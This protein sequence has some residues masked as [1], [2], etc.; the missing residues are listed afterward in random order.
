MTRRL[1]K[2]LALIIYIII[3]TSLPSAS[4]ELQSKYARL[5]CPDD[6]TLQMLNNRLFV[7]R[8]RFMS[9]EKRPMTIE[10]EVTGKI[11]L[12]TLKVQEILDMFPPHL[13]YTFSICESMEQV[14]N[15]FVRINSSDLKRPGFYAPS[16]D[17]VYVSARHARIQVVAHEIGHVVVDKYFKIRP[18]MKIHELLSQFVEKHITD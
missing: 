16:T 15:H 12:I 7:S 2:S 11:D 10:D 8:F 4:L 1:T 17:T 14:N 18:P 5:I 13:Q 6:D 3:S 9:T